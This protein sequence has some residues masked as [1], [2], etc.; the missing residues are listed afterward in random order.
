MVYDPIRD[1]EVPSPAVEHS[2]HN[3]PWRAELQT[4]GS[5][6]S[7]GRSRASGSRSVDGGREANGAS[8][9]NSNRTPAAAPPPAWGD[10][11]ESRGSPSRPNPSR[12]ISGGLRGLLNDEDQDERRR[13]SSRTEAAWSSSDLDDGMHDQPQT[14]IHKL[15]NLS[16][17]FTSHQDRSPP[18]GAPI[19]KSNSAS[20]FHSASP[21]SR[22][23]SPGQRAHHLDQGGFL[24]P[25]TPVHH[26]TPTPH[27]NPHRR[28]SRSPHPSTSSI[29]PG[30][31]NASLPLDSPYGG[32][33]YGDGQ[34][35]PGPP[36]R[37]ASTTS[38]SGNPMP[39]PPSGVLPRQEY[40]DHSARST[41]MTQ[42]LPLRS[43]SVSVSPR[44]H[45]VSLP[46]PSNQLSTSRPGSSASANQPF[47]FQPPSQYPPIP[48]SV[49]PTTSARRLSED[50]HLPPLSTSNGG[51]G[52]ASVRRASF[53]SSFSH[54][55]AVRSP[56]PLISLPPYNPNRIS[57]PS[58]LYD[59]ITPTEISRLKSIGMANN[60]LRKR[61][62]LPSWSAN[63]SRS[64]PME[65]HDSYFPPVEGQEVPS[66]RGNSVLNR[67][68]S[69]GA[70][71]AR[72]S[73]TPG[74][75]TA[76]SSA[77]E[78]SAQAV[79]SGNSNGPGRTKG[80]SKK[81]Q[82]GDAGSGHLKR[83]SGEDDER[84]GQRRK[85]S[86]GNAAAVASHCA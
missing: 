21:P 53:V 63:P 12:S 47:S 38:A 56:S 74:R 39:P 86:G 19:S 3:E 77:E 85:V 78:V 32:I 79:V 30:F 35:P 24:T 64:Q 68:D 23:I 34:F 72:S 65:N 67:R 51:R 54:T 29:S 60:P 26:Q 57:S 33:Y 84:D 11:R 73:V 71:T 80:G 76:P 49:S 55:S 10:S 50:P 81:R 58:T 37:R 61:K 28:S 52:S 4:P 7:D 18:G 20:S 44:S 14:S 16:S 1:C 40:Y 6:F 8:Y 66:K 15:L 13:S 31:A 43:P 45:N 83:P 36:S 41:P 82:T 75:M 9:P 2:A 46:Y 59:P 42:T 22:H 17:S 25:A 27:S 69:V 5:S 70:A 48:S 62:P